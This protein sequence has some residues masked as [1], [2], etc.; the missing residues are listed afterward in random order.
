MSERFVRG[1]KASPEKL[2]ALVGNKRITARDVIKSK[3][4]ASCR[5]DVLMTLGEGDEDE[6]KAIAETA[7]TAILEKRLDSKLAY[8]YGRVTEMLLNYAALPLANKESSQILMQLTYHV[9]NDDPGRW[10][11]VLKAL[12]LSKTAKLWA[13]PNFPF[14]WFKGSPKSDWPTWT[15]VDGSSLE[16][17]D[18]ELKT[19]T[20]DSLNAIPDKMLSDNKD[21]VGDCRKEFFSAL[22]RLR[23]WVEKAQASEG[24][25]GVGWKKRGNALILLMDGDQ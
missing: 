25:D 21:Y 16:A 3:A 1:W 13:A 15:V 4:N 22:K 20:P 5:E 24:S 7:L 14:P 2:Q 12:K 17:I 9:P 19:V 8:A 18:A 6:G 11:P 10:N 23:T